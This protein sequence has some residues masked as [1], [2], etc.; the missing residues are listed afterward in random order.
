MYTYRREFALNVS[1]IVFSPTGNTLKVAGM[2]EKNLK[3]KG[4]QVQLL[5]ITRNGKLFHG[6][7]Y[8]VFLHL[9][10][11]KHDVLVIGAPV[12]AHHM[13]YNMLD[14]V[15][16]L[17]KVD[18]KWGK[19]AIPFITY[20]GISSGIALYEAAKILRK[21]GRTVVSGMK[22]N[23][24]HVMSRILSTDQNKGM[25]GEEAIP[26][27]QVLTNRIAGISENTCKDSTRELDYQ[28][29]K[30]KIKAK[31]IFREKLWQKNFYP[32][33]KYDEARCT[34]CGKCVSEC[35]VQ[36]LE[37]KDKRIQM[38]TAGV[39]CIHCTQC[40]YVCPVNALYFE[41]DKEKWDKRF[42]KAVS[43]K[44]PLPSNEKSTSAVYPLE[45]SCTSQ[46]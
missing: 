36:R 13:H 35:P 32:R 7:R 46:Y 29:A 4:V 1:I 6:K 31:L 38:G 12:Y 11:Q 39:A 2:L 42:K 43:G 44:G 10:V 14:V 18:D 15:K 28:S 33:L 21:T 19:F 23:A 16:S 34:S 24:F 9:Y 17:P 3:E 27:A 30:N 20:G 45:L 22:I 37:L 25:P 41:C 8:N 26:L 5:D 40:V